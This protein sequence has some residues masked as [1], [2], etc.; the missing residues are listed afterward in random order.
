MRN[1]VTQRQRA[2]DLA[3]SVREI[4]AAAAQLRPSEIRLRSSILDLGID[5][6][7]LVVIAAE[8]QAT[9]HLELSD[10]ELMKL[11]KATKVV[12]I[13]LLLRSKCAAE[14]RAT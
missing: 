2:V 10:R 6:M 9:H 13:V 11:F 1:A 8:I 3:R 7:G 5:S 14:R 12:D 4:V